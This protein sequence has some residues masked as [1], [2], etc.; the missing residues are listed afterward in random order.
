MALRWLAID[1]CA[2]PK[3]VQIARRSDESAPSS[4][5]SCSAG[6]LVRVAVD[7]EER[8]LGLVGTVPVLLVVAE[9]LRGALRATRPGI[10]ADGKNVR[11]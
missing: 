6:E 9:L 2:S 3:T 5:T 10:L 11:E 8:A 7:R 4:G 1:R